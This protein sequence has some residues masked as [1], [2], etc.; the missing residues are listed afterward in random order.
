MCRSR[1][2]RTE[3]AWLGAWALVLVASGCKVASGQETGSGG[4]GSP[5]A[6]QSALTVAP[7]RVGGPPTGDAPAAPSTTDERSASP[8]ACPPEMAEV[9]ESCVDRYEAHLVIEAADGSFVRHPAHERPKPSTRYVA[10]S[11]A[12]VYPQAYISR[13]EAGQAC[14][15]AG[16]RLCTVE[17]WYRACRGPAQTPF[18]YGKT[19]DRRRCN[20]GKPHLL[21]RFFG[22]DPNAWEYEAHFNN[23]LLSQ[24]PGFLSKT[25]EYT[26]CV[27]EY[28]V[29]DMVGNLHEW[30]ADRVDRTLA[31][32]I[33]LREGIRRS[34]GRGQGKGVFLGGFY[35]TTHEH[36]RGCAFVT[37]AHEIQY[38]DYSVG[39]RCCK[40]RDQQ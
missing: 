12:G 29:Y 31:S 1:P 16:K 2:D 9:G 22:S 25:G 14:E 27:N 32:K 7:E 15:N 11:E 26:G 38:H 37:A 17:E 34:L 33:P 5:S 4:G 23:P 6:A 10:R 36:G 35:S 13:V 19:F 24:Q 40:T 3:R 28:G 18:P 21:S 8:R 20:V 30:V 39:F